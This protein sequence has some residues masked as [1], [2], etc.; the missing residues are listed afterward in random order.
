MSRTR[1]TVMIAALVA[2]LTLGCAMSTASAAPVATPLPIPV[3]TG[4]EFGPGAVPGGVLQTISVIGTTGEQLGTITFSVPTPAPYHYQYNY[5]WITVH[6][7]NLNSGT[8]GSIDLRHWMDSGVPS[9]EQYAAAL[10][11]G[12]RAV[13]GAGPVLVTVTH[14]REQYQAPPQSNAVIP[15]AGI[16]LTV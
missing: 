1:R 6:W 2:P 7:R 16:L 3:V 15:G 11:T 9:G 4:P 14:N 13:T 10:P 5:R 12:A 8:A